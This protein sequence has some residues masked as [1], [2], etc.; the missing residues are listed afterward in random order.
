MRRMLVEYFLQT[1]TT[2]EIKLHTYDVSHVLI[3]GNLNK[4]KNDVLNAHCHRSM[5]NKQ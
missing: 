4:I 5:N 1:K 3:F 2:V